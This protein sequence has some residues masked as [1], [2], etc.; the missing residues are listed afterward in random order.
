MQVV[1]VNVAI[2]LSSWFQCWWN[3]AIGLLCSQEFG[4][5]LAIGGLLVEGMP[6]LRAP[7]PRE[8]D[9]IGGL[10]KVGR[11]HPPDAVHPHPGSA[12]KWFLFFC[13]KGSIQQKD[14]LLKWWWVL[15]EVRLVNLPSVHAECCDINTFF[16][17]QSD[18]EVGTLWI[19]RPDSWQTCCSGKIVFATFWLTKR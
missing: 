15:Q 1:D 5:G 19:G 17:A 3:V 4:Y 9:H 14:G 10:E 8:S 18:L 16:A 13:A 7:G 12:Q 6:G 2:R 11:F